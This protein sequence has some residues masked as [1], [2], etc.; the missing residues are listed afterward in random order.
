[1]GVNSEDLDNVRVTLAVVDQDISEELK[2]FEQNGKV[3]VREN[4]E[5]LAAVGL[6]TFREVDSVLQEKAFQSQVFELEGKMRG[7]RVRVQFQSEDFGESV[8]KER[9]G[10]RVHANH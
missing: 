7:R 4:E 5:D 10:G 1:M 2:F 9:I 8:M 6:D 3:F